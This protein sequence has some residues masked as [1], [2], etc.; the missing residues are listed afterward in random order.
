MKKENLDLVIEGMREACSPA[1]ATDGVGGTAYPFFDF[2]VRGEENKVACKTG[3]AEVGEESAHAWFTAFAP[4][5]NPE[6]S[7]TVFLEEGGE[8]S[9]EAAPIAREILEEYFEGD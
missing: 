1:L 5:D 2:K 4:I 8:G 9:R 6:I 7:V 3:T